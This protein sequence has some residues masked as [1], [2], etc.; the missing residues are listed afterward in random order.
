MFLGGVDKLFPLIQDGFPELGLVKENCI[1]MSWVE[2]VLYFG[3]VSRKRLDIL[4]YR[5]ALPNLFF[6]GKSDYVKEPI[7]ESG[8]EGIWSKFF[9]KEAEASFMMM[10]AFGGKMDAIPE[11]ELPYSHRVGNLFQTSYLVGWTKDENAE[12]QKYISWIRR[13]YSYMTTYVSEST[14]EAYFNYRDLDIGTN[15]N[16]YTSYAQASIWGLKYFKNNF[17][18]LV[19][20]KTMVDPE[21]FFQK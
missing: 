15:N 6:K 9:E 14:R 1:E 19:Q 4:L 13:L 20:A 11:T 16:G 7:P 21:N 10:V 3:G 2:S 5:N 12:S 8:F 18:R 17:N